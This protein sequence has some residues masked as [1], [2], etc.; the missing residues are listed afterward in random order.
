MAEAFR[1]ASYGSDGDPR[2]QKVDAFPDARAGNCRCVV[3]ER[4]E[5][6]SCILACAATHDSV[7]LQRARCSRA[8]QSTSG[9]GNHC[10]YYWKVRTPGR[11]GFE[12]QG[13]SD[14]IARAYSSRSFRSGCCRDPGRSEGA[15]ACGEDGRDSVGKGY[16]VADRPVGLQL[17]KKKHFASWDR[18]MVPYPFSQGMFLWGAPIMVPREL[19]EVGLEAKRL[20]LETI[21]NRLT[22][23]ADEAVSQVEGGRGG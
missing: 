21:L 3:S 17:L 10:T 2:T 22:A 23:Q 9:R 8:Y 5:H 11:E 16:G 6:H 4:A 7:R 14:G 1:A 19:D 18:F 12:Y 13:G 20:E 15:G